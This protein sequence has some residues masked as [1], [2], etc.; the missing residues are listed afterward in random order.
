M[1]RVVLVTK[2]AIFKQNFGVVIMKNKI[3][4]FEKKK[5]EGKCIVYSFVAMEKNSHKE[6]EVKGTA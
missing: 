1:D 6:I 2:Q 4:A 3:G 5:K